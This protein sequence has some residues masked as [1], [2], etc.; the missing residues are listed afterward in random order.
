MALFDSAVFDSAVFDVGTVGPVAYTLTCDTSSYAYTGVATTLNYVPGSPAGVN[1]TLACNGG[2]YTY[3]GVASTS[4]LAHNLSAVA[5]AY[6]YT[7][8]VTLTTRGI[9]LQSLAGSYAYTGVVAT[10]SYPRG[11][12]CNAGTYSYTGTD[13]VLTVSHTLGCV[14]GAYAYTGVDAVLTYAAG[15][16]GTVFTLACDGGSY[17]L[18]GISVSVNW[19]RRLICVDSSYTYAGSDAVLDYI[20][21]PTIIDYLLTCQGG[22]YAVSSNYIV[23]GYVITGYYTDSASLLY[24]PRQGYPDPA[25]VLSGTLYGPTGV[26]YTGTYSDSIR[27]NLN[28][29]ELMKPIGRKLALPL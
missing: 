21:G 24:F 26:E 7:G 5:G 18:T 28:T 8:V 11:I 19:E 12:S 14:T 1:Y 13:A 29:G 15:T 17:G 6:T 3:T 20:A 27:I 2:T 9:G 22:A 4:V 25:T 23:D 10:L 16:P